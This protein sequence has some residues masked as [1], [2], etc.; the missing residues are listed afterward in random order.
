MI[1]AG[2]N[3]QINDT[4]HNCLLK[5]IKIQLLLVG[6]PKLSLLIKLIIIQN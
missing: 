6:P 4:L 3:S 2:D 5:Y 1:L